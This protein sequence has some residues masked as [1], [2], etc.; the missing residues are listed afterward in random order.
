MTV[1]TRG[2]MKDNKEDR[3][4]LRSQRLLGAALVAL[5]QE[6]R[7]VD[8]TVQDILDR[9]DV[10][11]STFYAHYQDKEDLLISSLESVLEQSI[12]HLDQ[13]SDGQVM[14][15]TAEFFRHVQANRDL[16]KAMLWGR[17]MDVLFD[18]GLSM[19]SQKIES[20]LQAIP[21]QAPAVP[22]PV[23]ASFLA[24]SFLTLLKWWVENK[25]PCSPEQMEAMYQRLVMPGTLA[26]LE[27]RMG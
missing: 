2:E 16:Y 5:M 17:G 27:N 23:I 4:S 13:G 20:H 21:A 25:L 7:Y 26:A 6:K 11:R 12:H 22:I 24:G 18:K 10:G 1:K 3:R 14:L 19:L 9:A 8:I 15:S